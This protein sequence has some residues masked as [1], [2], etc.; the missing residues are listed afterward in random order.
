MQKT[1]VEE[2]LILD[3]TNAPLEMLIPLCE[4]YDT[5]IDQDN[6]GKAYMVLKK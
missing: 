4:F 2:I 3:V 6:K 5:P 1:E